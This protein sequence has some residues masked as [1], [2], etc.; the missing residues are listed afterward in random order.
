MPRR[1]RRT[2]DPARSAG[3]GGAFGG[4]ALVQ[5]RG[6]PWR[7]LPIAGAAAVKEYRCPGCDQVVRV[8]QGH[9]VV[10]SEYDRDGSDRRHWHTS[11]WA[12]RDRRTPGVVR[13]RNAPRYGR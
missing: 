13:S 11:C 10:W 7:V 12:A 6:E 9:V 4:A 3:L 8:G 1:N 5:W 2:G